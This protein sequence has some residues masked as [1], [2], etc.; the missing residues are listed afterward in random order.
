MKGGEDL[1]VDQRVEQ[2]FEVMNAVMATSASCRRARLSN[3]TYKVRK[4]R[5]YGTIRYS[6]GD[7]IIFE[8]TT[9]GCWSFAD[10]SGCLLLGLRNQLLRLLAPAARRKSPATCVVFIG[11]TL[12][13][14]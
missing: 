13:M 10:R 11:G 12:L 4:R 5:R 14:A 6:M 8:T 9:C 7:W 3:K 1:R 2:L